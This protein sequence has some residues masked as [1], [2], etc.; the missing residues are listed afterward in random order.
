MRK[1]DRALEAPKKPRSYRQCFV[2]TLPERL[3]EGVLYVSMAY[4]TAAHRCFCGCGHE[5]VT[6]IH[7]T[8]WTLSYDGIHVSLFPSVGSWAL[9]CRS[10]YWL[11]NGVVDWAENNWSDERVRGVQRRDQADQTAFFQQ[12]TDNQT[13]KQSE[14]PAAQT[15]PGKG[16]PSSK[17]KSLLAKIKHPFGD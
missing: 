7:P 6:P 4:A 8:K 12:K 3:E 1:G 10:H 15:S 17:T 9:P 2:E 16:A 13:E 5:V 11:E 14:K